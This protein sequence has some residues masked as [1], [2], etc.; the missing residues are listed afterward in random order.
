MLL[1]VSSMFHFLAIERMTQICI[2]ITTSQNSIVPRFPNINVRGTFDAA[3]LKDYN[4]SN[5][6]QNA[7]DFFIAILLPR[8][9]HWPTDEETAPFTLSSSLHLDNFSSSGHQEPRIESWVTKLGC[10]CSGI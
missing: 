6:I 3:F 1:S 2:K 4:I 8:V 7:V 10:T 9:L 5:C